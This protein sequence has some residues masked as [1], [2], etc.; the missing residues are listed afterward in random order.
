MVILMFIG[1]QGGQNLVASEM[2]KGLGKPEMRQMLVVTI[3][4]IF[5]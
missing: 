5:K 3:T 2:V 1:Q 4:N